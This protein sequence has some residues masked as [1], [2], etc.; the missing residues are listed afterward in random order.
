[1]PRQGLDTA[2][3]VD[4]AARIADAD[5]LSEVTLA[6]VAATLGVR[7]PSLY[8]HVEGR[9]GLMRLVSLRG[10]SALGETLRDAGVG[11]AGADAVRA[12][13]HAYRDFAR[14]HPGLYAATV[15]APAA[16][17]TEA[18]EAAARVV[19]VVV[20]VLAGFGLEGDLAL[21]HVRVIRSGL[22]GFVTI[23]AAG[24]WG[25]PLDLDESFELLLAT[26]IAGLERSRRSSLGSG[27]NS[28]SNADVR[29]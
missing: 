6:R 28:R 9:G 12:L 13:G 22:H 16:D 8:N 21:H 10:S 3:V 24:G 18:K 27:L 19:S 1:V 26:L 14:R 11:R 4:E 17:D 29:P 2:R 5:G 7:A 15:R 20:A 25:L 23:E